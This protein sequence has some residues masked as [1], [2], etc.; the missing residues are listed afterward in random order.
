M[1]KLLGYTLGSLIGL[2]ILVGPAFGFYLA[3]RSTVEALSFEGHTSGIVTGCHS[4]RP[5]SNSSGYITTPMV[6][7]DGAPPVSGMTDEIRFLFECEELIGKEL[8]IRYDTADPARARIDT[9][10]EMWF[11]PSVLALVC[12]VFYGVII[13]TFLRR[14]S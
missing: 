3:S 9:F 8:P 5:L 14:R 1:K 11:L 10:H 12:T 7:R 4:T 13:I 6:E 2:L